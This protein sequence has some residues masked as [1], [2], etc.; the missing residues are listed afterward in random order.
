MSWV[1]FCEAWWCARFCGVVVITSALHAEGREFEP[2]QNLKHT[3]LLYCLHINASHLVSKLV[4]MVCIWHRLEMLAEWLAYC[5]LKDLQHNVNKKRT[6]ALQ[7]CLL[8][9]TQITL[10][11]SVYYDLTLFHFTIDH[12]CDCFKN[13]VEN[14]SQWEKCVPRVRIELTTLG[15]WDLRAAYCAIE[16]QL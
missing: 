7:W 16:A 5:D 4:C 6:F 8:S 1:S 14:L 2:R 11:R 13:F 15:L 3:I 12:N 9:H 10:V